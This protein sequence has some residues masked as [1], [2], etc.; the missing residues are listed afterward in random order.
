VFIC[1]PLIFSIKH[2]KSNRAPPPPLH[3]CSC[4]SQ[5]QASYLPPMVFECKKSKRD[6][7]GEALDN[8]MELVNKG[9][10]AWANRSMVAE[11]DSIYACW[12]Q[13]MPGATGFLPPVSCFRHPI[14]SAWKHPP[15]PARRRRRPAR[16]RRLL[17]RPEGAQ[18][19]PQLQGR[20][21]LVRGQVRQQHVRRRGES[22][23]APS[24]RSLEGR[25]EAKEL[26]TAVPT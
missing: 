26:S 12:N 17:P 14:P 2:Q 22:R 15:N 7:K 24:Q 8:E 5:A 9:G 10:R 25:A 23:A 13:D 18:A 3:I 11:N 4:P 20:V 21:R 6:K 19:L 16:R 1:F